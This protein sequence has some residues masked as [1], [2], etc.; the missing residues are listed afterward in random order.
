MAERVFSLTHCHS[1]GLLTRPALAYGFD[2]TV[3][4]FS[5]IVARTGRWVRVA[6]SG[7]GELAGVDVETF[8]GGDEPSAVNVARSVVQAVMERRAGRLSQPDKQVK[9][10]RV[11]RN[12]VRRGR[13]GPLPA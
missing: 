7:S 13:P 11:K 5:V 9:W 12:G 8:P 10:P 4:R 2:R 3:I 6:F 1:G